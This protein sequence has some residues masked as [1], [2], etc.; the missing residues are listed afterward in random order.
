MVP[1]IFDTDGS[2]VHFAQGYNRGDE[3]ELE[4]MVRELLGLGAEIECS[5][6][7]P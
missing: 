3:K 1:V 4:K 6:E 7:K 5:D 2:I